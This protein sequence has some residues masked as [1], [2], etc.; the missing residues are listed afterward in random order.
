[1]QMLDW[2]EQYMEQI[3]ARK[4]QRMSHVTESIRS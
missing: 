1:V 4:G 3:Q 2:G